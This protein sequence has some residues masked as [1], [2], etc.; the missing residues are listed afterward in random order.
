MKHKLRIALSAACGIVCLLLVV[1]WVRSMWL[2]DW[3]TYINGRYALYITT[4]PGAWAIRIS[5]PS[6]LPPELTWRS[7]SVTEEERQFWGSFHWPDHDM[8]FLIFPQWLLILVVVAVAAVPW[9]NRL[10]CFGLR[11]LLITTT[12]VAVA[13]GAIV[14]AAR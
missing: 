9:V 5:D 8:P 3:L 12:L 1:L 6:I 13:L 11:T 4:E 14:W 10:H 7:Y 2:E